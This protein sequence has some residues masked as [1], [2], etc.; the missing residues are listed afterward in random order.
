MSEL[1][2]QS[3]ILTKTTK[4]QISHDKALMGAILTQVQDLEHAGYEFEAAEAS[5]D[6]LVK[7]AAG[8]YTP[9][10]DRLAYRVNIEA[11]EVGPVT[12][13]TVKLRVG[14][15]PVHTVAESTGP[16][17]ALDG[18]LRL[19]LD[20]TYPQLREMTLRDYK[21]R[22][23]D[24]NKGAGALTRVLIESGDGRSIWATVGVSDNIIDASW[25]ALREAVEYKL[26]SSTG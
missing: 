1:S 11:G 10:F 19:A 6:L 21:V 2:G 23:L 7:K 14:G 15:E 4:Y 8:L 12:E 13:A 18:A 5:F 24:S 22:I 25:D 9:W 16:V 17:G 20:K 3:T 26:M